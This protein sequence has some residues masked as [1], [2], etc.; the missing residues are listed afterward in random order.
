[1]FKGTKILVASLNKNINYLDKIKQVL[2]LI[3]K[4]KAKFEPHEFYIIGANTLPVYLSYNG[5]N[6]LSFDE[7][8]KKLKDKELGR[9]VDL[10]IR[11]REKNPKEFYD[12]LC[13][14]GFVNHYGDFI[15]SFF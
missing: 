5:G 2:N 14:L 11:K 10:V 15:Y 1:M 6:V 8:E 9:L 12:S 3:N 13:G 4:H 7:I